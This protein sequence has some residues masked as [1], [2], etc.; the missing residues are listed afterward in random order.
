[1]KKR[2]STKQALAVLLTVI[3]I[4]AGYLAYKVI[5]EKVSNTFYY[6]VFDSNGGSRV[7]TTI[8]KINE[9]A[10]KPEDPKREGYK[11]KYWTLDNVEYDFSTKVRS[12]IKLV[13]FWEADTKK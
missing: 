13:A 7:N 6:V 3:V 12:N 9:A 4:I 10:E 5:N 11:F 1:M 2:I 8:V